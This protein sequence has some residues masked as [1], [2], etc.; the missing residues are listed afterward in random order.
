MASYNAMKN[1]FSPNPIHSPVGWDGAEIMDVSVG[2]AVAIGQD[3]HIG[4]SF[5]PKY[6]DKY[7]QRNDK[8]I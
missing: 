6:N 8:E 2:S 7:W 1:G 5:F 3:F 4:S